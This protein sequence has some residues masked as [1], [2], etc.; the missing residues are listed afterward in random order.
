MGVFLLFVPVEFVVSVLLAFVA[1]MSFRRRVR[2]PLGQWTPI[3]FVTIT[4][5]LTL[6]LN[7]AVDLRLGR[8][9]SIGGHPWYLL[10]VL[11]ATSV[12]ILSMNLKFMQR[13]AV[14]IR[15]ETVDSPKNI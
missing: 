7:W 15:G 1:V 2:F 8:Y 13:R 10:L 6:A 12:F 4:P 5:F 9:W 14:E 11:F 3:L